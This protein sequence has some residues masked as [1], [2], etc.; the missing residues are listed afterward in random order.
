M[1]FNTTP[2]VCGPVIG[3]TAAMEGAG[4]GAEIDDSTI[5]GIKVG[6]MGPLAGVGDPLV[7]GT[8]RRL[9][10]RSASLALSGNILGPAVLLY[11]QRG[12]PGDEVVWPT[13]RLSQGVNIV[14]DM[15]GNLLQNSPKARRFGLFVMG[16]G[17]QMD[18][19]QRTVGGFHK[20]LPPMV[21]P[22]P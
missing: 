21:P 14:G 20:R 10:P 16:A 2:A 12:A 13:A 5:N 11:F 3:V 15:G 4:N 6:L 8:L 1:F 22:S 18:V 19:N 17:D 7:W 9:P